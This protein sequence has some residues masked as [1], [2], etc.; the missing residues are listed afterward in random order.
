MS[1]SVF[2]QDQ[3]FQISSLKEKLTGTVLMSPGGTTPNLGKG[4]GSG[5]GLSWMMVG[6]EIS[7][8]VIS[9]RWTLCTLSGGSHENKG[10]E[11][12]NPRCTEQ[13]V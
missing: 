5:G 1:S 12:G 10:L 2:S 9:R 3:A 11:A 13:C 8:D 6:G 4:P 7:L